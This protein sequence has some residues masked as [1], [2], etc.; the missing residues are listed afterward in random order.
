MGCYFFVQKYM[1]EHLVRPVKIRNSA[2]E[3]GNNAH[4]GKKIG[5]A[6]SES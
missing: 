4:K 3:G 5:G 6:E 2:A 1:L